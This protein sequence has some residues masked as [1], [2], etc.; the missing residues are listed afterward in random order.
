VRELKELL[1]DT[2][3]HPLDLAALQLAAIEFP[4]LDP[5]PF[6]DIL[7]S[8]AREIGEGLDPAAP[9]EEFIQAANRFLFEQEGFTGN[10]A[11]YYDPR[12]SCLNEVLAS[13]R[14]IPITLSL[15]YM[16][17]AR[18]LNRPVTGIGLPGHFLVRYDDGR[19]TAFLDPFHKGIILTF[20]ECRKRAMHVARVDIL[21][22]PG[23]LAPVDKPRLLARMVNNLRN[24]YYRRAQFEHAI[25]VHDLVIE[26][27][28]GV[29]TEYRQRA[30]LYLQTGQYRAAVV[31]LGAY[32]RL[33]PNAPDRPEVE[34]QIEELRDYLQRLN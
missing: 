12:N 33:A 6:L 3:D 15:I 23:A 30:A 27:T 34:R 11:D 21:A 26:A 14:G 1:A 24:A 28:P 17:V 9:G 25:K 7:D 18:R 8:Y 19:F 10:E 2:A 29:A 4:G 13:R 20:E 31:D 16:E 22:V 5:Q 32:L